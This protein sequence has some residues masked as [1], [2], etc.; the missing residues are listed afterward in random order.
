[1][2]LTSEA[3]AAKLDY[4]RKW[5]AANREKVNAYHRDWRSNNREKV[6]GYYENYWLRKATE[7]CEKNEV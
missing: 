5:R 4:M 7:V 3:R 2:N 6:Q 1:M